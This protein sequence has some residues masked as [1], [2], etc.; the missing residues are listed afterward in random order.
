MKSFHITECAS[1]MDEARTLLGK[2]ERSP[3]FLF[4]DRQLKGRGQYGKSWESF[5][6]NLMM[7]VVLPASEVSSPGLL[8]LSCGLA[9]AECL[10]K[11]GL[12]PNLVW[13]NDV[14]IS[15]AKT[16]GILVE[17]HGGEFIVGIGLNL[18]CPA[19]PETLAD[20]RLINSVSFFTGRSES[21]AEWAKIIA[22]SVLGVISLR[23]EEILPSWR[24]FS[25]REGEV[26]HPIGE[27]AK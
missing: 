27:M 1:T 3:F 17:E 9:V 18:N 6:G 4:S 2:G 7:S 24:S 22:E 5:D 14:V 8:S 19:G 26:K 25:L 23:E 12:E 15:G 20:G 16:A 21:P 11:S 10:V 13:P